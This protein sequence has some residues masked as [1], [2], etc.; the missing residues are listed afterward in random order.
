MK[1]IIATLAKVQ[2]DRAAAEI[3]IL[4]HGCGGGIT[5]LY[6]LAQ[7]Y[8]GIYGIDVGDP[9]PMWNPLLSEVFAIDEPR[10]LVYDGGVL[11][12]ADEQFDLIFSQ[13]VVEHVRDEFIDTYYAEEGRVL[14][15]GGMVFHEV[16][17]RL[18]PYDS[19]TR[20]WFIHMFPHGIRRQLYRLTK[21]DPDYVD[22]MLH[23]RLPGFHRRMLRRHIGP[24][25]D[26]TLER[27]L[28][29]EDLS[30]FH[31]PRNLRRLARSIMTAPLIGPPATA[32]L[33]N[34]IQMDTVAVKPYR[35][36]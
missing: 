25:T 22:A 30:E 1:A 33:K 16:P 32:A 29:L 14:K 6:L 8:T 35:P 31:G 17:H 11:P 18:Y 34:L 5:L 21:N 26:Q 23:L 9:R 36:R 20:T 2:G 27:F 4:D 19:H 15:P 24:F 28:G 12:L 13:Q 7:G 10:F 3:T